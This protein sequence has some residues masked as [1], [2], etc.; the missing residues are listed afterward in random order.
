MAN[1]AATISQMVKR[2]VVKSGSHARQSTCMGSEVRRV[3]NHAVEG[4][5][6]E[7]IIKVAILKM[8]TLNTYA[9]AYSYAYAY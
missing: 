8:R 2:I 9:F 6:S 4:Q 3:L 1:D 5:E 7:T